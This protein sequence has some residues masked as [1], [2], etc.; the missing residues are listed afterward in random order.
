MTDDAFKS[1]VAM[2]FTCHGGV[3]GVEDSSTFRLPMFGND[4]IRMIF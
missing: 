4:L 3:R 1:A 2:M